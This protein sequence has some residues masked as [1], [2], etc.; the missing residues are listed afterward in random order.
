MDTRRTVVTLTVVLLVVLA[1]CNAGSNVSGGAGGGDG[2]AAPEATAVSAED[3]ER[4]ADAGSSGGSSQ[5]L[6]TRHVIRTGNVR[7]RVDDYD[8]AR[9]NL[10]S[11]V[12]SYGGYVSDSREEVH[13]VDNQS[14]TTG[15]LVLR[16]PQ[17]NFSAMFERAKAEGRIREASTSEEDV[18]GQVVDLEARLKNLRAERDRLRELYRQANETED[19]IAVE[20]RLSE[21]QGEIERTEARLRALENRV[22]Y[23][24]IRVQLA[25]PA[26]DRPFEPPE[27]WY[28]VP[29]LKAFLDSVHGVGVVI[30]AIG[31]AVAY[32]LPYVFVFGI[33]VV[34]LGA[35]VRRWRRGQST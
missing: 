30:R 3:A 15:E 16:V 5:S 25:E 14:W 29:L 20:R 33:P 7:L 21:V 18:T 8:A 4:E 10:T 32:A 6:E 35:A 12:E 11:A 17:E 34:T 22:A 13:Q 2:G 9:G 26:P 19:V 28:D 31:V 24:T 27:Q 1:G 23:S